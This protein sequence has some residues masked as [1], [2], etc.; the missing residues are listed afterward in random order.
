MV[1]G[2]PLH[3]LVAHAVV[4]CVPLAALG[5]ILMAFWPAAARRLWPAVLFVATIGLIAVPLTTQSGEPLEERVGESEL[6]E[7]HAKQ[8]EQVLPFAIVLWLSV[9]GIC[10]LI[11]RLRRTPRSPGGTAG[12]RP[13]WLPIVTV[14]LAVMALVGGV[15]G[16]VEVV[17]AGHSGAKAVWTK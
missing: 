16:V 10:L 15:G 11:Y 17:L 6:V 14:V 4:V 12:P 2:L 5:A 13:R 7:A 3:P 1:F 8:G 9:A